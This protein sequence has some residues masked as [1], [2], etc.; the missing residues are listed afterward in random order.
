MYKV[1]TFVADARG[2]DGVMNYKMD[3]ESFQK[4]IDRFRKWA[5][6]CEKQHFMGNGKLL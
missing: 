4:D 1:S 5:Q 2:V 3:V 6:I